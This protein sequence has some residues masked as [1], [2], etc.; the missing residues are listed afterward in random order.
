MNALIKF[1]IRI[2]ILNG[3]KIEIVALNKEAEEFRK[4]WVKKIGQIDSD[5]LFYAFLV[6]TPNIAENAKISKTTTNYQL[7]IDPRDIED[8]FNH[9][10]KID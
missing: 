7:E 9:V 3:S 10:I 4:E 8:A 1:D 2:N 6:Q 5:T